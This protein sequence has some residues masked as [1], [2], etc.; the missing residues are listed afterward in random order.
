MSRRLQSKTKKV[1]SDRKLQ[2]SQVLLLRDIKIYLIKVTTKKQND[3]IIFRNLPFKTFAQKKQK[4]LIESFFIK[5]WAFYERKNVL[6]IINLDVES[7]CRMLSLSHNS[8]KFLLF[9]K[10]PQLFLSSKPQKPLNILQ[11]ILWERKK[12]NHFP[13]LWNFLFHQKSFASF[14]DVAWLE[15]YVV[16]QAIKLFINKCQ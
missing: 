3:C 6:K 12:V 8:E 2:V 4:A 11:L 15:Q 16:F 7:F 10:K 14:F 13:K 1:S 9:L 5:Q